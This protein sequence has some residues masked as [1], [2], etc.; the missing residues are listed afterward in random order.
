MR[1]TTWLFKA[2]HNP[3]LMARAVSKLSNW[4]FGKISVFVFVQFVQ[5]DERILKKKKLEWRWSAFTGVPLLSRTVRKFICYSITKRTTNTQQ[6]DMET[7]G[8]LHRASSNHNLRTGLG[9][10]V[11]PDKSM[12]GELL[13]N[14]ILFHVHLSRKWHSKHLTRSY[15]Q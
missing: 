13:L 14:M 2:L 3:D 1:W 8:S 11:L 7:K 9:A 4:S 6:S 5:S 15:Y 10:A 12:W